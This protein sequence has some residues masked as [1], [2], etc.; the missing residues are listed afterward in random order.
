ATLGR[1]LAARSPSPA[2]TT[3][4]LAAIARTS[5]RVVV[6]DA[7]RSGQGRP[8]RYAVVGE[9][10]A[11]TP[12]RRA[13]IQRRVRAIRG[14]DVGVGATAATVKGP[15]IVW[16]GGGV[17]ANEPSGTTG[18]LAAVHRLATDDSCA[19][20]RILRNVL[21]VVMP[22]QNPDGHMRGTRSDASG[23]DLNRDWFATA[24][25]ESRARQNVLRQYPPGVAIDFH[26]QT[27]HDYF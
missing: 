4:V 27:G 26:E 25:P 3:R 24:R 11:L 19:T 6:A 2:D 10:A 14:G 13:A 7:G 23:F 5:P 22:D 9:P 15:A 20:R 1:S 12:A 17:H 8:L 16:L 21:T 18:L